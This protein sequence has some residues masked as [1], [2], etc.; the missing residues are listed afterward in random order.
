[1]RRKLLLSAVLVVIA[2][3]CGAEAGAHVRA[4]AAE[5]L[6]GASAEVNLFA[7][8]LNLPSDAEVVK[9]G[10]IDGFEI[11]IKSGPDGL[12]VVR[13]T[14]SEPAEQTLN[15]EV[16]AG[17]ATY[18]GVLF[19]RTVEGTSSPDTTVRTV[20]TVDDDG[21]NEEPAVAFSLSTKEVTFGDSVIGSAGQSANVE[22][23]NEGTEP[24]T[25]TLEL[26]EPFSS[27][28]AERCSSVAPNKSCTFLVR[29]DAGESGIHTE[30]SDVVAGGVS[31][32]LALSGT[33]VDPPVIET[34][35]FTLDPGP[36]IV[37]D[38]VDTT[39]TLT[40][41]GDVALGSP[42]V[43]LSTT[44]IE[45]KN[46]ECL[47]AW[48]PG[49]SC[50]VEI[51]LS[52]AAQESFASGS[53]EVTIS[54]GGI[55]RT[56]T[57]PYEFP[58]VASARVSPPALSFSDNNLRQTVTVDNTGETDLPA[59]AAWSRSGFGA[60]ETGVIDLEVGGC[61]RTL[62]PGDQCELSVFLDQWPGAASGPISV[63]IDFG[64][65]Y[66]VSITVSFP[67]VR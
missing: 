42:D 55:N 64:G 63:P 25:P 62:R 49:A 11:D 24:L 52:D 23:V 15:Y 35:S 54:T 18:T 27:N 40:N 47:D 56:V 41:T 59:V 30:S 16:E 12:L 7:N 17:G 20:T 8:D 51:G 31:V 57:V 19:V 37:R 65:V 28:I 38:N 5:L 36:A 6:V 3:S 26:R 53:V 34:A 67:F 1:M 4:D 21:K 43:S 10:S 61:S 39:I 13:S 50:S 48:T 33:V 60:D 45:L 32:P 46:N 9:I 66:Q 44:D 14:A 29:I 58:A 2:A 22:I